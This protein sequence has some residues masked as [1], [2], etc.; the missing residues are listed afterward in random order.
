MSGFKFV[1]AVAAVIFAAATASSASGPRSQARQERCFGAAAHDPERPC[2]NPSLERTVV[3]SPEQARRSP[4]APCTVIASQGALRVCEFGS[5]AKRAS[6]TIALIGDSHAAHWR[7]ALAVVADAEKWRGLSVTLSGCPY[8]TATRVLREPLLTDCIQRN[9]DVSPWLER[10][11]EIHTV[12]VS[13][14]SG[15]RWLLPKDTKD[16]LRAEADAYVTAWE[17][18]PASV[19]HVVVIRDNP[20]AAAGTSACIER[21]VAAG[22]DPG[23]RCDVPRSEALD[24]DPALEAA[25]SLGAPRFQTIDMTRYFCDRRWCP[26]VIGGALVHKDLH[27]LT[28]VFVKTLGPFLLDAVRKLELSSN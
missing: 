27:H 17:A 8:S 13:E 15:A 3:P 25:I 22:A 4:N 21:A 1:L 11:P 5:D 26:P 10:H 19:Q 7:A 24:P 16:P 14:L 20:K 6:D 28:A 12:F 9:R 23:R 18:L 2:R